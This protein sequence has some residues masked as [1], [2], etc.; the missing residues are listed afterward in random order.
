MGEAGAATPAIEMTARDEREE[1][2]EGVRAGAYLRLQSADAGRGS[3]L[4][5][6]PERA[7]SGELDDV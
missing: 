1:R 3:P 6:R 2:G 7:P 5:D 4:G